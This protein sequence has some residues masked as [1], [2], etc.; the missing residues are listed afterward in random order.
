MAAEEKK[1]F[2]DYAGESFGLAL[3]FLGFAIGSS[4][5][6]IVPFL[7]LDIVFWIAFIGYTY[8]YFEEKKRIEEIK[9]MDQFMFQYQKGKPFPAQVQNRFQRAAD[10]RW[11]AQQYDKITS[12]PQDSP[13]YIEYEPADQQEETVR[14][15]EEDRIYEWG[16]WGQQS[17]ISSTSK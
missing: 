15:D 14:E 16:E 10:E 5:F 3:V 6:W 7:L 4:G 11:L 13:T 17:V 12:Q 2:W 8:E 9:E 1:G